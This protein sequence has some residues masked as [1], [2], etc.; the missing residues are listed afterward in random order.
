MRYRHTFRELAR[1]ERRLSE[2]YRKFLDAVIDRKV[3]EAVA[4]WQESHDK[5][6]AFIESN[7]GQATAS[8]L[9]QCPL[10]NGL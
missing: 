10:A 4:L 2:D 1:Y 6:V 8:V 9:R 5:V 7:L 3:E